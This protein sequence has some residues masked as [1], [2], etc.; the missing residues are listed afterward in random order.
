MTIGW[1]IVL[2]IAALVVWFF[3]SGRFF[4]VSERLLDRIIE[5]AD[6]DSLSRHE[7]ENWD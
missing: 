4:S 5:R 2:T 3:L 6:N 1:A 7:R